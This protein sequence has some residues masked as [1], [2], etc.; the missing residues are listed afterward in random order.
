LLHSFPTRRSS[1]LSGN[2]GGPLLND[3]GQVVGIT[4]AIVSGS[5]GVGFAIPSNTILREIGFLINTG[6]YNQHPWLGII[7]TDMTYSIAQKM[8]INVTYGVL[9]TQVTTGGPTS[10]AGL[11]GYTSIA[12]VA[13]SSVY[14]GGDVIIAINEIR[15]ID[16]DGLLTCLEEN[17]LPNQ[18]INM[19]IVRN[20][21]KMNVSILLGARPSV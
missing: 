17:T 9:I 21:I 20:G 12:S 13:G 18:T 11:R 1:D 10:K 15:I 5:T 3:K 2:S 8:N 19:T 7:A 4:T 14:I 6:S 16:M